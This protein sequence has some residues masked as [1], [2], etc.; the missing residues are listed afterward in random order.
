MQT[1]H[2]Y[3]RI[4]PRHLSTTDFITHCRQFPLIGNER[5]DTI[6]RQILSKE[7]ED[8]P[9]TE[10]SHS[11]KRVGVETNDSQPTAKRRNRNRL[12]LRL[13]GSDDQTDGTFLR[14]D[15]DEM[16]DLKTEIINIQLQLQQLL[17]K[18][19]LMETNK[20][21]V[22]ICTPTNMATGK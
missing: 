15:D 4:A 22:K 16:R 10:F 13:A 11:K 20:S 1:N 3:E 7:K 2:L 12:P 19:Y 5:I 21:N 18:L 14:S 17:E 6:Q 9:T 8:F